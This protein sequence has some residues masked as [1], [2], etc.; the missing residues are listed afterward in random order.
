MSITTKIK[1]MIASLS[2]LILTVIGVTVCLNYN[3]QKDSNLINIV[4]KQRMLTQKATKEILLSNS[5]NSLN[6]NNLDI[7]TQEFKTSLDD[8]IKGNDKRGIHS[9]PNEEIKNNLME[10]K[11]NWEDFEQDIQIYKERKKYLIE[12]NVSTLDKILNEKLEAIEIK[13]VLLLNNIDKI[14]STYNT[15][16]NH[17]REI[18]QIFQ[19]ISLSIATILIIYFFVLVLDIQRLFEKFIE[20][21][22]DIS[23]IITPNQPVMFG[24]DEPKDELSI[25]GK[26]ID[27]FTQHINTIL[28]EASKA[29][30]DSQKAI[31][32]LANISQESQNISGI[33]S[34]ELD[35][36]LDKSE[37]IA[38]ESLEDLG[39]TSH[40]LQKLQENF[41]N[42]DK[43]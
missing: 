5:K 27:N 8:L 1:L 12:H 16:F 42:L 25:A 43:N 33:E 32:R 3:T 17:N 35:K 6:F 19:Y 34:Q 20:H 36:I 15:L 10:I 30:E 40:L 9:A 38:I 21:S 28:A 23:N 14:V 7:T 18:L 41:S 4:G 24:I 2:L 29:I 22:K 13:N 26:H 39:K 37:N 11:H 31:E